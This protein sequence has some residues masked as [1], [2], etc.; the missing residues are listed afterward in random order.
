MMTLATSLPTISPNSSMTA[1]RVPFLM[2]AMP[3]PRMKAMS[4]ALMT[5]MMAGIS[6]VNRELTTVSSAF[7]AS[8][9]NMPAS[10]RWG[11]RVMST[12]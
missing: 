5:P 12:T 3:R 4:R 10:T 8:V 7:S 2:T 9:V 6:M 1:F 11:N